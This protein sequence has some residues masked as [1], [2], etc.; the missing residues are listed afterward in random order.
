VQLTGTPGG[1]GTYTVGTSQTVAFGTTITGTFN[2]TY[3]SFQDGTSGSNKLGYSNFIII[4]NNYSDTDLK[5]KGQFNP[6]A[7]SSSLGNFISATPGVSSGRLLNT[8]HQVQLVFRIITRDLDAT[9][10]IRPDNM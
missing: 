7:L 4:R 2:A 5:D 6:V 3:T 1:V 10:K 9:T 8:S